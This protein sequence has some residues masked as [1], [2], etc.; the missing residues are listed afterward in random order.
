MQ[1][2]S[3]HVSTSYYDTPWYINA[4][5]AQ[6]SLH[7]IALAMARFVADLVCTYNTGRG[8]MRVG[9]A[10]QTTE[11]KELDPRI[12]SFHDAILASSSTGASDKPREDCCDVVLKQ[13]PA[14]SQKA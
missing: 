3:G 4:G 10:V 7:Q 6:S 1:G 5:S 11:H 2:S 13:H 8:R 9:V 14:A 12:N